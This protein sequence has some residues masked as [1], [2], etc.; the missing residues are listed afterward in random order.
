MALRYFRILA[1]VGVVA[2]LLA[3]V[4][5]FGGAL[6]PAFDSIGIGRLGAATAVAVCAPVALGARGW[7]MAAGVVVAMLPLIM[8]R[9]VPGEAGSIGVYSK[10]LHF[11]NPDTA[12]ITADIRTQNP[13]VVV[14]Q[15]VSTRNDVILSALSVAYPHQFM[16]RS[17][18]WNGI[19]ILSK[20]PFVAASQ[21]CSPVRAL[22]RVQIDAVDGPFWVVGVHLDWP[23]P[24]GQMGDVKRALPVISGLDGHVIGGFQ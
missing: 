12:P 15:E 6:H 22:A 23:W 9:V 11:R 3:L 21:A 17:A 19:A 5:G 10:N 14:L 18:G 1:W 13:D 24:K 2:G 7:L 16:C 4:V 8:A 20:T